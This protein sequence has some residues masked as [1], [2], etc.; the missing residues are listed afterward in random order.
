MSEDQGFATFEDVGI[1]ERDKPPF[2]RLPEPRSL[3]GLRAMR[4]DALAPGHQLEPYLRFLAALSRAQ[5]R[6]VGEVDTP[7][8]PSLAEERRRAANAM[9][10]VPREELA[11]DEAAA[12][13]FMRLLARMDEVAMPDLA[14]EALGRA[15]VADE[16]G[17]RVLFAAVLSDAVPAETVADHIFAAA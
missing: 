5:D 17:R 15:R 11:E 1:A 3:F 12:A 14:R 16:E 8:L 6:L 13:C 4:F 9:P 2:L 7:A 10:V